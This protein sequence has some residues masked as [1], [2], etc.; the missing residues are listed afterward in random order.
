MSGGG[1]SRTGRD[2]G[3]VRVGTSGWIYKHWRGPFYP[4]E[5]PARRWFAYY[6][7]HFDT[8]EVNNS[9]Y[10]LPSE[11]TFADWARQAP[12]GFVF[13]VK[14]SRYLTHMKKL[15]DPEAPLANVLGHA[16]RLGPHL[17]PVL[18][19]LPPN[20]HCNVERLR[21]FLAVLPRDLTHAVEFRDPSWYTDAVREAL[22]ESG[23]AF[24]IHDLRGSASPEWVTSRVVYVRLHG[25]TAQAYAGRYT[26][27]QLRRWADRI[28]GWRRAGHT[29]Y[30]YFNND[31]GGHA[32]VNT[33]QLKELLG[34][35]APAAVPG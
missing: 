2:R 9:F 18:Y 26:A 12:P 11:E 22:A 5:L 10:R 21:R 28:D 29:V 30:A 3:G 6:G 16:R 13:A 32:V 4:P 17:G 20:W 24:C 19:Q 34:I 14:A 31:V 27:A 8:V 33:E 15:N 35:E 23:V 25:P 1:S 7:E